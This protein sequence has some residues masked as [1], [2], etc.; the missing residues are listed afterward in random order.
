[1][2]VFE[3][4]LKNPKKLTKQLSRLPSFIQDKVARAIGDLSGFPD[5]GQIKR[6]N[7]GGYR[8]RVGDYRI[9]FDADQR[10]KKIVIYD[11]AHRREAY[12]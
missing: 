7:N 4:Y 6:L 3:V 5:V 9:L 8:A 11:V 12:R 2:T 1:M 10:N